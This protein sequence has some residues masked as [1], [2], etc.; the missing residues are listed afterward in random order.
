MKKT[1]LALIATA[2]VFALA[3][4]GNSDSASE[5]A[6]ADS[7]EM[8]ADEAMAETPEPL[9]VPA[10]PVD[11]AAQDAAAAP[12]ASAP[13]TVDE[14]SEAAEQAARDVE[15]ATKAAENAM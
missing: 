1:A 3:A 2:S 15:A 5:D 14:I 11:T 9:P 13:Q 7:V 8:P 4:C 12:A 6:M 10:A